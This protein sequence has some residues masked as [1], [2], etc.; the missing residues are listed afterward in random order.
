MRM[1]EDWRPPLEL[2]GLK[3][4]MGACHLIHSKPPRKVLEPP[5]ELLHGGMLL[6]HAHQSH[7]PTLPEA[8]IR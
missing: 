1:R 8:P 7:K 2:K 5:L 4:L 3:H 6:T